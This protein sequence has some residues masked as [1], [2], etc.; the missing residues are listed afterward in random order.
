MEK[1]S[2]LLQLKDI[3]FAIGSSQLF[4]SVDLA[5]D[6]RARICLVGQNGCGKSTLMRLIV[7]LVEPDDGTMAIRPGTRITYMPQEP[8]FPPDKTA[9]E[10]ITEQEHVNEYEAK[11]LLD[12]LEVA[13]DKHLDNL[14]GG[15]AR[16]VSLAF[17]LVTDPDILLLD[18]PT[19]HL[20]VA[21]IEWLEN[22][23]RSFRGSV[24]MIS[25]DRT[26]LKNTTKTTLWLYKGAIRRL[27]QGYAHFEEWA[28]KLVEEE[29]KSQI[30]QDK[31]IEAETE[32]SHGGIS[33]RRKRNQGRLARLHELRAQRAQQLRTLKLGRL[34]T[35]SSDISSKSIIEVENITKAYGDRTLLKD[36]TTKIVRGDR[37]G[38]IGP[39]GSGKTTLLKIMIGDMKPDT[40]SVKISK[41]LQPLYLDQNRTKL[42]PSKTI[43]ET[44]CPGGGDMVK[45]MGKPKHVMAYIKEFLFHPDQLRGPV[46]VLSGGEKNRL[47]LALSLAQDSNLLI[48]DEPTNDLD[49][50]TLDRLQDMLA[51]YDGTLI[52]VSHDRA[53]LD[54]VVTSTIVMEGDGTAIE[55]AGGY[56]D[57]LLQKRGGAGKKQE[58][59]GAEKTKKY[60]NVSG[61]PMEKPKK[62]TFKDQY[63]LT[64]LPKQIKALDEEIHKLE[65]ALNNPDLYAAGPEK[66]HEIAHD[67]QVAKAKK[68]ELEH[69]WLELEML[70]EEIEG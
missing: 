65:A 60:S 22:K 4:R 70:R 62:L 43:L 5:V 35:S 31:I 3:S 44:L 29:T 11:A 68:D 59:P 17:A 30:K 36:F 63:A 8:S 34:E 27:N 21:T 24:V 51:A 16:R 66:A 13:Y 67:L 57:Y 55:Y 39:N 33:A 61:K 2:P 23:L 52:I 69:Q 14:S 38:I 18:E 40:G 58:S 6:S 47:L 10:Y 50:D 20:D 1:A 28:D 19:N 37:I 42:D 48:L 25:H 12:A 15:E 7:G 26:F 56:E 41:R 54:N 53:F 46:S 32:W 45:V 9:L 64:H 49:M